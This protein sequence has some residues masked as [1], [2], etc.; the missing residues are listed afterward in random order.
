[1]KRVLAF[2]G[3]PWAIGFIGICALSAVIW[4]G[5]DYVRFGEDNATLAYS[6]RLI[7]ILTIFFIWI[8]WR[9]VMLLRER[10]Q[11]NEML[12]E[13]Q[14]SA[15]QEADPEDTRTKEE[16]EALSSRF[17]EAMAVLKKSRFKISGG[18]KTLYQLPWYII[19]GPPGCGKTTAL[20]NSG[21]HFPLASSHGKAS[22]G[23]IGGTRHCDWWFT[24]D[25]VLIDTSGRYTTQDS[26]RV[27]DNAAWT[28]FLDLLKKY[29][30]RRPINGAIVAIS[31]QD[32]ML[33]TEEQRH[34]HAQV[35]RARLDELRDKLGVR[36]P[37]YLTFTKTDLIAGFS[38]FFANLS[39]AEREQVWGMTFDMPDDRLS[40]DGAG[41]VDLAKFETEF[42]ELIQRLNDRVLRLVHQERDIERRS[43]LQGF[44]ARMSSLQE[45]IMNFLLQAFSDNQF[46]E[47]PLLRGVYLTSGTQE[48]TP[49]DRMMASVTASFGLPRDMASQQVNTGKSF[50]IHRLLR[51]VIFPESELVGVN[52]RFESGLLWMRRA[53][54]AGLAIIT[55][56][57]M[58][59]WG[60][61]VGKNKQ[62]AAEVIDHINTYDEGVASAQPNSVPLA[63]LPAMHALQSASVVYDREEHP[64]L[65]SLGLYDAKVD[66]TANKLYDDKLISVFLPSFKNVL[67]EK[68]RFGGGSDGEIIEQLRIYLMLLNPGRRDPE[69]IKEW[70]RLHWQD[71][72]S[73]QAAKQEQLNQHL[74]RALQFD[75]PAL[76]GDER[77]IAGARQQIRSI[78]V[79][80]RLYGQLRN[81][82]ELRGEVDIYTVIGGDTQQVFGV[83]QDNAS[84]TTPAFFT[85]QAYEQAEY[86]PDSPLLTD[87]AQDQWL[88]GQTEG[89]D[90]TEADR[91]KI[92]EQIQKIYL[93]EYGQYWKGFLDKFHIKPF[94]SISDATSSLK[95]M[96]DPIN[97]PLQGVLEAIAQNTELTPEVKVPDKTSNVPGA[98]AAT[99]LLASKRKP[100]IVDLQFRDIQ[101]LLKTQN[102]QS[103]QLQETL[104]VVREMH[105]FLEGIAMAPDSAE[106]AFKVARA[107]FQGSGNDVIKKVRI[108][109]AQSPEPV[110]TWLNEIAGYSWQLILGNA[111]S[112]VNNMWQEQVYA[113]Y[114]RSLQ[115]RYPLT[116]SQDKEA[117]LQ[118]FNQFF[119]PGGIEE[120]F[121]NDY[122]KPFVSTRN[123]KVR[124]L[125]GRGLA[126]SSDTLKQL[127]RATLIRESFYQ[128]GSDLVVD[129]KL[130][131]T[132]LDSEVRLFSLELGQQRMNYSHGPRTVKQF[133]W[134]EAESS[135]ARVVFEDLNQTVNRQQY[136]GD[137]SWFRLFDASK[138]TSTGDPREFQ[139]IF[140]EAGREAKFRL[141]AG[142]SL[143]PFNK[144]LLR[145][146]RLNS[147]L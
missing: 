33:Q 114:R 78:P 14:T 11:N 42:K 140:N 62:L 94:R 24:N 105:D 21:L 13:I 137:W 50:F 142:S 102:V 44:P 88:Y 83:S 29:R 81:E 25:A 32:L 3:N 95:V 64:W 18:N 120:Q 125:D 16:M 139:V 36:F 89:E 4:F 72:L 132:K 128:G 92:S 79:P 56:G 23:G 134:D 147:R 124:K 75:F 145:S 58:V 123:W 66:T 45:N 82:P 6:T 5:A 101:G 74:D 110:K 122:L 61:S 96:A 90:F 57:T 53:S 144:S 30:R 10:S 22:L 119:K 20:V 138:L 69:A 112:Y 98:E 104:A 38:E 26:H 133:E 71:T 131:P 15:V 141:I 135:R 51:D 86:G 130:Q 77:L 111:H 109:A 48:G 99:R 97:S 68:L 2:L 80:Q 55:A 12:E 54:L 118:D 108:K 67:E 60:G 100:T 146:Y 143:N 7:I 84:F 40:Q 43:L 65:D 117:P 34:Q 85:R 87:L 19:I 93:T 37:V 35:I 91:K 63:V 9:L 46:H 136:D 73:G 127:K 107:R 103:P 49:I 59:V 8:V 27:V 31:L 41:R 52:R 129:F 116:I 121:F 28:G 76:D 47:S 17:R 39:Q 70:A 113:S 106:Q 126:V 115:G 1:M